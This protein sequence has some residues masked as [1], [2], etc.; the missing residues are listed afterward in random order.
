VELRR[1]A[2]A[3]RGREGLRDR[4]PE[5]AD[6]QC[7]Q[8][9]LGQVQDEAGRLGAGRGPRRRHAAGQAFDLERT[10][11]GVD[12]EDQAPGEHLVTE[13]GTG[14]PHGAEAAGRPHRAD[15][16]LQPGEVGPPDRDLVAIERVQV[17][18]VVLVPVEGGL[19]GG[20]AVDRLLRLADQHEV[21]PH[22]EREVGVPHRTE[23]IGHLVLVGDRQDDDRGD[24]CLGAGVRN[25][26]HGHPVAQPRL[27]VTVEGQAPGVALQQRCDERAPQVLVPAGPRS[28]NSSSSEATGAFW[29]AAGS[30]SSLAKARVSAG[31]ASS[32]WAPPPETSEATA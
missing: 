20:Q 16:V 27:D 5:A 19:R 23:P 10:G 15:D 21:V 22:R 29:L 13:P 3:A 14:R 17:A 32:G 1:D 9:V 31:S 26:G 28:G 2:G 7:G 12:P 8:G 18:G 6:R 4:V 30:R 24:P 11:L 25:G